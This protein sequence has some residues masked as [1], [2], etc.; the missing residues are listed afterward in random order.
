MRLVDGFHLSCVLGSILHPLCWGLSSLHVC[1]P[2]V[3][4]MTTCLAV[5]CLPFAAPTTTGAHPAGQ[6]AL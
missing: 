3:L 4:S 5:L 1:S 6:Q 2:Q